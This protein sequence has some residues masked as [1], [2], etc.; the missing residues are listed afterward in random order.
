MMQQLQKPSCYKMMR[1][2]RNKTQSFKKMLL[3]L[4]KTTRF[5]NSKVMRFCS[6][7]LSGS[8]ATR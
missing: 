6:K 5:G 8:A 7:R 2:R 3:F 4:R 1:F